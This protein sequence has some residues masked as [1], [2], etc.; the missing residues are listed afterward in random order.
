[1]VSLVFTHL[2]VSDLL[3][4]SEVEF[5]TVSVSPGVREWM[6]HN[7]FLYQILG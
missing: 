1:M 2:R 3:G 6:T 5:G 7:P 4:C